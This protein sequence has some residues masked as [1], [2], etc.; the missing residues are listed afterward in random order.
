MM[1]MT[2]EDWDDEQLYMLSLDDDFS[3]DMEC[4]ECGDAGDEDT[5]WSFDDDGRMLCPN[6]WTG[7]RWW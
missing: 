1:G 5:V 6:C 4:G 7:E 2:D 3:T